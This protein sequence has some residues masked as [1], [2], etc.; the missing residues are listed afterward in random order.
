M[1]ASA[2]LSFAAMFLLS[3][4]G[5]GS[6]SERSI[7]LTV[8]VKGKVSYKGTPFTEGTVHFEPTD[9]G[10][11]ASGTIQPDGTFV[12]T[13]LKEGD[14][15][16]KGIH[17]VAVSLGAKAGKALVPKKYMDTASSQTEVEVSDGKTDYAVDFK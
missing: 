11:A 3:C 16:A 10:R 17:R 8:P 14:G 12:L 13:T 9:A 2:M 6:G 7:S 4:W 5:C 1:R 15:A